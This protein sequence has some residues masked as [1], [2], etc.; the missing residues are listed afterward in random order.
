MKLSNFRPEQLTRTSQCLF[1]FPIL[2][3]ECGGGCEL[4]CDVGAVANRVVALGPSDA[5]VTIPVAQPFLGIQVFRPKFDM[6]FG[7]SLFI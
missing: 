5:D 7:I 1:N 3:D 6:D 4:L 2:Y